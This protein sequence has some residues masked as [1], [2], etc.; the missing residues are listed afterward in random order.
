MLEQ[1]MYGTVTGTPGAY[2]NKRRTMLAGVSMRLL[3]RTLR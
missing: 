3:Q 2:A 1:T